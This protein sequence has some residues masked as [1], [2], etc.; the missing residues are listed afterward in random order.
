MEYILAEDE[1]HAFKNPENLIA[2][3]RAIERGFD[4]YPGGR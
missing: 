1:G 2:M 3:Y 4:T